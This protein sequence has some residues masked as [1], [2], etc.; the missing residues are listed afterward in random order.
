MKTAIKDVLESSVMAGNITA[1]QSK[2][3]SDELTN[4]FIA[5]ENN[6][7]TATKVKD[8]GT[9]LNK[10]AIDQMQ[11]LKSNVARVESKCKDRMADCKRFK[12]A[13]VCPFVGT[14]MD[15]ACAKTCNSCGLKPK[16]SKTVSQLLLKS[17]LCTYLKS[18]SMPYWHSS[19]YILIGLGFTL[20]E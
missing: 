18:L 19:V 4:A 16:S 6:Q 7:S 13:G 12:D 11:I 20:T 2:A 14:F 17:F 5:K 1:E 9:G 8:E 3:I 15:G 10:K